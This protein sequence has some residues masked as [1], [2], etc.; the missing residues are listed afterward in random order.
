MENEFTLQDY[1]GRLYKINVT[2]M[3]EIV[4]ITHGYYFDRSDT[5]YIAENDELQ[6]VCHCQDKTY[7]DEALFEVVVQKSMVTG[8]SYI[9]IGC[10]LFKQENAVKL[11]EWLIREP[12]IKKWFD[13]Y[14][15]GAR[16]FFNTELENL[17]ARQAEKNHTVTE[18]VLATLEKPLDKPVA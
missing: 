9:K 4:E 13:E 14:E 16:D 1:D 8:W 5:R 18:K 7:A 12:V 2:N 3:S 6:V 17:K 15:Q 10:R 11:Y